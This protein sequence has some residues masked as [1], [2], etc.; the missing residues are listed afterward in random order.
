MNA[1]LFRPLEG[2]A[3]VRPRKTVFFVGDV[4]LLTLSLAAAVWLRFDGVIPP[5]VSRQ[6]PL[7]VAIALATKLVIFATQGL[8]SLSWAQVGL[9][10]M[11]A[12]FRGVTLG[13]ALFSLVVFALR[14][15]GPLAGFPR[16]VLLLDYII[17]LHA[18]GAFRMGR[19]VYQYLLHPRPFQGRPAVIV[20][21]GAAGEQLARSLRQTPGAGY[22]LVGFIDDD[23]SKRNTAIHGL[24][25]L[26]THEQLGAMIRR[27]DVEAVLIAM[28][29][30][31]SRMIRAV[32]TLA[33]EAGVRE[34][35]IVPGID[36]I[37]DGKVGFSDLREVDLTDLLGRQVVRIDTTAVDAWLRGR[38]V[39]VTGAG[40]SIGSELCRQIA[41]FQPREI[42]VLDYDETGLFWIE[43][44]LRRLR[45]PTQALLVD[46]RDAGRVRQVFQRVDPDVV[47]HAAAYKHVGLM[48]RHPEQAVATNVLGTLAVARAA[49]DARVEKFVLISTDKAVHPTSMMGVTKRVAE[50]VCLALSGLAGSKFL[51]VRFGNVLGSRGSVVPLFQDNIRRG[52]PL[53]VRGANM[54]RY[55]MATSEAV[56]LVLQAGAMG[57]GG[58]IFALD[59]GESV[60]IIELARE[61]IR[62]SGLEPDKDVPIVLADAEPGEKE[63]EDLLTAEEGMAATR[64]DQIFA[65]HGALNVS[66]DALFAA[67]A[68]LEAMVQA[69][70]L[71]GIVRM[72][73]RLVPDYRPS[74]LLRSRV[75]PSRSPE[76]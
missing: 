37:L 61:L 46:V 34:I 14:A 56:L 15:N 62:L 31:T 48:E 51:A 18:I 11:V 21:A 13:A 53:T 58:E 1:R 74:E 27:H 71:S 35:R 63:Q 54:R 19:R 16:S 12:V 64:H 68:A 57:Q 70:D 33:R 55:F 73:Q 5:E 28:P 45:Q 7:V 24:R 40:G 42:A 75:H 36:Q 52:E 20:G 67:L 39:L 30:A 9:E 50:Q 65:A 47:F 49:L 25:V 32:V 44:E 60:R 72:L 23:L 10:D 41:R 17:T 4:I 22:A 2:R 76:D 6:L 38:R 8:Y 69:S 59:M 29:S 66:P 26:G 3:W 43:Q